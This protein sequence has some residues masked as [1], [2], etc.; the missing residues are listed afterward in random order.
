MKYF[1]AN[2]IYDTVFKYLMEDQRVA[3]TIL[4]ALL[5]K[6]VVAVSQRAHEHT[7]VTKKDVTM[8]RIDFSAVVRDND[9]KEEQILI[10]LQKTW[11][12][13]ETLRF[14][15]Y[16]GAQYNKQENVVGKG[17]EQHALPMVAVYIL[18]HRVGE[19]DE[20]VLYVS[21]KSYD[22][23]GNEVE[24]GMKDP[25]V[26]SLTHDSII[27]QIPL[28]HGRV[29]PNLE[30]VL[31]CFDQTN[32]WPDDNHIIAVDESLLTGNPEMEYIMRRLASAAADPDV[33]QDMNVEDEY[34][35]ALEARDTTL[36]ILNQKI[37]EKDA[38]LEQKAAQL[39]QKD[40]QLEQKD[41]QLEQKDAQLEQNRAELEQKDKALTATVKALKDAGMAPAQIALITGLDVGYIDTI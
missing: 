23:Y 32:R 31:F 5:K 6:K 3:A 34:F 13:T 27:V 19:V 24:S 26:S 4:S 8:F 22:Y 7:N 14:R 25:F 30:K 37:E 2:P 15:Q 40:A 28:L 10:E 16:L 21:H 9:G 18:G 12:E 1:G 36:M 33:R 41:A 39:E 35:S 11:V 29:N 20:P 17:A 38:Q